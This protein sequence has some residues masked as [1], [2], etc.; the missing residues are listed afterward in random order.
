MKDS[1]VKH[2]VKIAWL[3]KAR[4]RVTLS[5]IYRVSHN[6]WQFPGNW[7]QIENYGRYIFLN[8]LPFYI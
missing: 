3:G 7:L 4:G 1:L 2:M 6:L 5:N 8:A